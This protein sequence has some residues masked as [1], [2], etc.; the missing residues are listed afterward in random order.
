[1]RKNI[2]IFIVSLGAQALQGSIVFIAIAWYFTHITSSPLV[3]GSIMSFRYIPSILFAMF[4]GIAI[5]RMDKIQLGIIAS[6]WN[7]VSHVSLL[8]VGIFNLSAEGTGYWIY[9]L[10]VVCIGISSSFLSP[11]ERTLIPSIIDSERLKS[12]NSIISMVKQTVGLVGTSLA[13][14]L[15][16]LG[17]FN[18]AMVVA[19]ICTIVTFC[20]FLYLRLHIQL[21]KPKISPEEKGIVNAVKILGEL[22]KQQRWITY[23]IITTVFTNMAFVMLM[24]VLLPHLFASMKW[25][26]SPILGICFT[27][28][29]IGTIIGAYI[30]HRVKKLNLEIAVI[31]YAVSAVTGIIAGFMADSFLVSLAL[32][33]LFS[34]LSA[35]VS[36]IYLTELQQI[37]PNKHLGS[38]QG[39]IASAVMIAQPVGVL[40]A[41]FLLLTFSGG[42]VV[43]MACT[44][45]L[46][47]I[48]IG[49][50]QLRKQKNSIMREEVSM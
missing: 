35:P 44:L 37:I 29:G 7:A 20:A 6:I 25:N 32:F 11:L 26:S 41:G 18:L 5:D 30:T 16:F 33:G 9:A 1:M 13:G 42:T 36:I 49:W 50:R 39:F 43:M 24:D 45:S 19:I 22:L 34:L 14:V 2:N 48:S 17:G 40:L 4:S 10:I 47:A 21:P 28:M 8:V 12:V 46:I 38:I 23:A 15:L 27:V 31:L 3:F